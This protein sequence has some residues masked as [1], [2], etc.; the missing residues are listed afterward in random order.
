MTK[1]INNPTGIGHQEHVPDER[2][3][4]IVEAYSL[5]GWNQEVIA[6][7]LDICIKTLHK[8][9]RAELDDYKHDKLSTVAGLA[10]KLAFDGSEKMIELLLKCQ[11]RWVPHKAPEEDKNKDVVLTLLELLKQR[12]N[13]NNAG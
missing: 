9:Y 13:N 3:K 12:E 4:A 2:S 10:Y 1:M 6:K 7:R 11:A 5:A 8:H